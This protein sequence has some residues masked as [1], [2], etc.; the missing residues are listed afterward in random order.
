[1][2]DID[3]IGR[4]CHEA[5]RAYCIVVGDSE[6]PAWDDLE[7]TYRESTRIGVRNALAGHTPKESHASWLKE[8][9]GA[10]WVL[11]AKLD[12][13]AKIHPNLVQY[14]QLPEAQKR[15]DHLFVAI[16]RALNGKS[17]E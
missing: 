1:M 11:G 5:N 14:D 9:V 16:T 6:L 15:K 13:T 8:R 3:A 12:R 2:M 17:S 10:G 7:E 4:V